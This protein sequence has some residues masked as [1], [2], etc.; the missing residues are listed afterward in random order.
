MNTKRV[1]AILAVLG[2]VFTTVGVVLVF[3]T[4]GGLIVGGLFLVAAA[5]SNL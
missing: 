3:G 5:S 1:A 2:A 4:P